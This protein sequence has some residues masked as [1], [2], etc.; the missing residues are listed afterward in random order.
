MKTP[1]HATVVRDRDR[2]RFHCR[3]EQAVFECYSRHPE[4]ISN[5]IREVMRK[6]RVVVR[7]GVL[8]LAQTSRFLSRPDTGDKVECCVRL[9]IADKDLVEKLAFALRLSQAE[10]LRMALEWHM[11]VVLA[12]EAQDVWVAVRKWHHDQ[13][14]LNV[15]TMRFSFWRSGRLLEWHFPS[16]D[17]MA[18]AR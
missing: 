6:F 7:G 14:G 5:G 15:E 3:F 10:V 9:T 18:V 12:G 4:R 17:V 13:P 1:K 8:N 16:S 2:V 11:D